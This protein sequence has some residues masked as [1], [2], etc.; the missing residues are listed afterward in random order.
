M[1]LTEQLRLKCFKKGLGTS[2]SAQVLFDRLM[3]DE[4]TGSKKPASKKPAKK[5]AKPLSKNVVKPKKLVAFKGKRLSASYYY[6]EV[7]GGRISHC[8]PMVIEEKDGRR[9]LKEIKLVHGKNGVHP[10]W[11]LVKKA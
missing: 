8:K 7:C 2:G 4:K 10:V 11:V 5:N 1:T 3:R 9:K 6:H